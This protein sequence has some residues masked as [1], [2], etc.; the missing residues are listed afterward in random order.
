MNSPSLARGEVLWAI[1][2]GLLVALL[3]NWPLLAEFG[4]SLPQG[5]GDP[6]SQAWQMAWGGHALREQPL[7][8]FQSN[9]FWPERDTLAFSDALL[10]YAPFAMIGTG[11]TAA[12]VRYDALFVL[13]PVLCFVATYLLA[14]ELGLSRGP[15]IVAALAFAYAPYRLSQANH[16]HIYSSGGIPLALFLL[17]RGHR[18][19][20][21]ALIVAGWLVVAWQLALGWS[22]GLL[23]VYLVT[24]VGAAAAALWWRRGRPRP[25]RALL[26]A[27]AAG[28][29]VVALTAF[30]LSRPYLAVADVIP[31][32]QRTL[33]D[34]AVWSA[35]AH[36]YLLAAGESTLWGPLTAGI[37][38]AISL[39]D[40]KSLFPGLAIALLALAGLSWGR[41]PF[42]RRTRAFLAVGIAVCAVLALGVAT[43]GIKQYSPY[44]LLYELAPGFEA[45]RVPGRITTLTTLGLALLAGAGAQRL[46]GAAG[47]WRGRRM[48]AAVLAGLAAVV[49]FEGS[50]LRTD[51]YGDAYRTPPTEP[52][53]AGFAAVEGPALHLPAEPDDNRRYLLWSTERFE[54]MVNGRSSVTPPSFTRAV[55]VAAS[56]PDRSS[57]RFLRDMGVRAVVL[58]LADLEGTA[59][60]GWRDR[61]IDG[62]GIRRSIGGELVVYELRRDRRAA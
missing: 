40:E 15:A 21:V 7:D 50:M 45:I 3:W 38:D 47:R 42:D 18:R 57:V 58:H 2:G 27:H 35:P 39:P 31:E 49:L 5:I 29:L 12:V 26:T 60:A 43:T 17:L 37:R 36:A 20:R 46:A 23:L 41:G 30:A 62:L 44:R 32:A 1:A 16:L 6:P 9:Q 51:D 28:V 14:R 19:G 10:G 48:Y 4:G 24:A 56:F 13:V 34:V 55:D 33:D 8:L 53:P 11:P 22:L 61:P 59:W 25:S 54:P 52:V